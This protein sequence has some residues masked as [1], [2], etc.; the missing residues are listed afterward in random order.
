M[1]RSFNRMLKAGFAASL[2]GAL[3]LVAFGADASGAA[4]STAAASS[5]ETGMLQEVLVTAQRRTEPLQKVPIAVNVIS[6]DQLRAK[7]LDSTV[8]LQAA[9]PGMDFVTTGGAGTVY[10]RG[11]GSN[12]GNPND[13]PSVATYVDGVYIAN[14][15]ANEMTLNNIERI[16]VLK[17]P[18]GTLFGRN[19]TG[20]VIQVITR[21]P[22]Q[23]TSVDVYAG[24]GNYQTVSGGLYA[25]TGITDFLAADIAVQGSDQ[26]QGYGF[27]VTRLTETYRNKDYSIRSKWVLTPFDGLT[28][29]LSL[30]NAYWYT[31]SPDYRLPAGVLGIDGQPPAPNPYD[32]RSIITLNHIGQPAVGTYQSGVSLR[33]DY[34]MSFAQ[35][36]S[37]SAY[38]YTHGE[39]DAEADTTP[40]P[41][42]EAK[43]PIQG[44]MASQEFQLL[45]KAGSTIN[46]VAG[47]YV[48]DNDAGYVNAEFNG[49]AF[50]TPPGANVG[51]LPIGGRQHTASW[52]PY[53]QATAEVFSKTNLTL[54]LRYT[55]EK[56]EFNNSEVFGVPLPA[57]PDREFRR[58]TWRLALDHEFTDTVRG[59]VSYNRGVKGGG[60]D[61]LTPGSTGFAPETLDAYELGL[62][63]ELLDRHLRF[64]SSFFWYDYKN[65]QVQVIPAGTQG[66]VETTNAAK[67]T[68]KG[69]DT[70]FQY[71]TPVPNLTF[72]GGFVW[73][74]GTYDSFP[75][76]VSYPASPLEGAAMAINASGKDTIRTPRFTGNLTAE[77][78]IRSSAGDFPLSVTNS[79]NSGY[80]FSA[81]N[82]L[83]QPSYNLINAAIGWNSPRDHFEA[84][85]WGHNLNNAYYLQ[86]GVPSGFGDLVSPAAPRTYGITLR[87]KF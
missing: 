77:Y 64:N 23:Q 82:R 20:G 21:D 37:I 15:Y 10:L 48:Y 86:Q 14:P 73:E 5:T 71:L 65:I 31:E 6:G 12:A 61:L 51:Q 33:V 85:L 45:S 80:F 3:P 74:K 57:V 59:W 78:R 1:T 63:S 11:V 81:D 46:W 47:F 28:F 79:Y 9:V 60:F 50:G 62:K 16:E 49:L 55:D 72:S 39:Y 27:A 41:W 44:E 75:N 70:D 32:T 25:T 8:D 17:G 26:H 83:K 67:A 42:V 13:E 52:S 4:D 69:W 84:T 66:I 68:I 36:V 53:A 87:A 18:Q 2:S 35:F 24:Y 7:G 43:L 40:L 22:T 56:Q 58:P 76:T 29:H 54:G 30:D 38:R 34:Q 19:A